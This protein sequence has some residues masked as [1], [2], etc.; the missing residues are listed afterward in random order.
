MRRLLFVAVLGALVVGTTSCDVSPPAATVDGVTISQSTLNGVL[1]GELANADAQC[2][3]QILAGQTASPVGIGTEGDGS[4]PNAVSPAFA[5]GQLFTLVLQQI[6]TQVLARRGVVVTAADVAAAKIDYPGQ[7]KQSQ[8]QNG[9]PTGCALNTSNPLAKQLPGDFL[10]KQATMLAVQEQFEVA[11]GH[12][13]VSLAALKSYYASHRSL[14][15]Q[16]CLNVVLADS[17]SAAQS[18]HDQI[19]TGTSFATAATAAG[20]D[21]QATPPGGQLQCGYPAGLD[22]QLGAT[23]GATIDALAAGQLSEPLTWQT[24]NPSTGATA[25]YYMV[26]QMRQHVLVPFATLR[27]PI[28]EAILAQNSAAVGALLHTQVARARVTVDPRYGSWNPAHGVIAPT[29]PTPA[30]VPNAKANVP[31]VPLFS[32][33]GLTVNPASG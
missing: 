19:A 15:T 5:D 33:P 7:L 25:T 32:T 18:L 26:V 2:A 31:V 6:E 20:A 8:S 22:S 13:D 16:E 29:P 30:F 23:L 12:V 11:I 10:Q 28:R 4:T 3:A 17:L 24:T 1:S 9:S 27:N 14:V 21:Q